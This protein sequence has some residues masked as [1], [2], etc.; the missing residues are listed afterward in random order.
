MEGFL[1]FLD[2]KRISVFL[3]TQGINLILSP[4]YRSN[5]WLNIIVFPD[6]V[7]REKIN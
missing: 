3:K 5:Y 7:G 1:V 6:G 4:I 2:K